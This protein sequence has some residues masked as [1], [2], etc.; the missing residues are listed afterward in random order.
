MLPRAV[1]TKSFL[2]ASAD[3]NLDTSAQR[4]SLSSGH[5]MD[6]V[7]DTNVLAADADDQPQN[8]LLGHGC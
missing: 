5:V 3:F 4:Q 8:H 1:A 6:N 2:R 7:V